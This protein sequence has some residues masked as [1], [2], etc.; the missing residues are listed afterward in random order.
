MTSEH[1]QWILNDVTIFRHLAVESTFL[2]SLQHA[3]TDQYGHDAIDFCN[4]SGCE[5]LVYCL[6]HIAGDRLDLMMIDAPDI[7]DV[8]FIGLN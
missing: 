4:L 1:C 3:P 2:Y 5:Q 8:L 7:V 6:T